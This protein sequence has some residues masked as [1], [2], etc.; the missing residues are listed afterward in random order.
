MNDKLKRSEEEANQILEAARRLHLGG[1]AAVYEPCPHCG[2]DCGVFSSGPKREG[3][4][5]STC[6]NWKKE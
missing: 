4:G 1:E 6:N 3:N 5:C 2:S